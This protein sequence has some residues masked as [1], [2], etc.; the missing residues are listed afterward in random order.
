MG[1]D[2]LILE[3]IIDFIGWGLCWAYTAQY[4]K[5]IKLISDMLIVGLVRPGQKPGIT[6]IKL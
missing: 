2:V 5:I 6:E 4:Y 3:T 1:A